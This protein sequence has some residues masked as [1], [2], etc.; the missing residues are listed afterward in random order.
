MSKKIIKRSENKPENEN[1][2]YNRLAKY[3][4]NKNSEKEF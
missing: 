1:K 2:F 3:L 4:I